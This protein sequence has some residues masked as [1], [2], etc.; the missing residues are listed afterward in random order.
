MVLKFLLD[1]SEQTWLRVTALL[2]FGFVAG[3]WVD[4]LLRK[5]DRS[6]ADERK[7]LGTE[8]VRLRARTF[9]ALAKRAEA[10]RALTAGMG[11]P[12]L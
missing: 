3:L 7:A 11:R 9:S 12:P 10:A 8:M 4:W 5:L 6:R 2:L 1:L